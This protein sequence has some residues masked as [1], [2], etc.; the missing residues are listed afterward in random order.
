MENKEFSLENFMDYGRVG[1]KLADDLTGKWREEG[2]TDIIIPSRGAIP[3]YIAFYSALRECGKIDKDYKDFYKRIQNPKLIENYIKELEPKEKMAKEENFICGKESDVNV[4]LCPF[5]A[6]LNFKKYDLKTTDEK[7]T[8][9]SEEMRE[10]WV[11]VTNAFS[12]GQKERM[13]DPYFSF[14]IHLIKDVEDRKALAE[15][16]AFYRRID[17]PAIIDTVISGLASSTIL[18]AAQKERKLRNLSYFL[19]IDKNGERLRKEYKQILGLGSVLS[20]EGKRIQ[21]RNSN[22]SPYLVNN[23]FT[24]DR[25][26]GLLGVVGVIYPSLLCMG[27]ELSKIKPLGAGSWYPIEEEKEIKSFKYITKAINHAVKISCSDFCEGIEEDKEKE[28]LEQ[29][30]ENLNKFIDEE[31]IL[32]PSLSSIQPQKKI[33]KSER[34]YITSSHVNHICFSEDQTRNI[35]KDFEKQFKEEKIFDFSQPKSS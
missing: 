14:Y 15:E 19:I 16:Y 12:K 35:F 4:L 32:L 6:D 29:T 2:L 13:R 33:Y 34:A 18:K 24:E 8:K 10:Y 11:K 28:E 30:I 23:I 5:T 9:F 17:R 26:A 7:N 31:Q 1:C 21:S 20:N 27:K 3:F 22:V 25:G